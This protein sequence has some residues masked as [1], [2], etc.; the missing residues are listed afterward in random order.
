MFESVKWMIL[1]DVLII[2]FGTIEFVW[3]KIVVL[4]RVERKL[5]YSFA[6]KEINRIKWKKNQLIIMVN[7][8]GIFAFSFL[9]L[10]PKKCFDSSHLP[11]NFWKVDP[12]NPSYGQDALFNQVQ[13]LFSKVTKVSKGFENR[14]S[15]IT[16]RVHSVIL[17]IL[18]TKAKI[19]QE[20]TFFDVIFPCLR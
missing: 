3:N 12:C 20:A 19:F 1:H 7:K 8:I 10:Q 16:K 2:G 9:V 11:V 15:F 14:N 13:P 4:R 17:Y 5:F 18:H 6:K